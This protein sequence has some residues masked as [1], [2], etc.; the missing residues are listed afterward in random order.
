MLSPLSMIK[1]LR[2]VSAII[3]VTIENIDHSCYECDM[4]HYSELTPC[5]VNKKECDAKEV[6]SKSMMIDV[7]VLW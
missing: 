4:T 6:K 3:P 2:N 5:V 7:Y 1:T